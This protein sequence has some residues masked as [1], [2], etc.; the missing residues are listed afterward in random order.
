MLIDVDK[1]CNLIKKDI[2]GLR[3]VRQHSAAAVEDCWNTI[4]KMPD[5]EELVCVLR[6]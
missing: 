5:F 1:A 6:L 2:F 3:Y 4:K